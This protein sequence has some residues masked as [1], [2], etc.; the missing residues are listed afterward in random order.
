MPGKDPIK[1]DREESY[2]DGF[3]KV[4][5]K[6]GALHIDRSEKIKKLDLFWLAN[7]QVVRKLMSN[8][9]LKIEYAIDD[10]RKKYGSS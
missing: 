3:I 5:N 6:V 10:F 2:T 7:Q 1:F 4:L 8:H 9:K